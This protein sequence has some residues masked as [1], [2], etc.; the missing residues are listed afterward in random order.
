MV[1][2]KNTLFTPKSVNYHPNFWQNQTNKIAKVTLGHKQ[3]VSI[4]KSQHFCE[5][6]KLQRG[7]NVPSPSVQTLKKSIG[8]RVNGNIV[9][10]A[11]GV[12]LL[13]IYLYNIY[14]KLIA[15]HAFKTALS[16]EVGADIYCMILYLHYTPAVWHMI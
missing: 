10:A 13:I 14:C 15:N 1:N 12:H 4:A 16:T 9:A 7:H 2:T 6:K 8:N 3:F 5:S 11:C